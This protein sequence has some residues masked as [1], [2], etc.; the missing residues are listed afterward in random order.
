MNSSS[1]ISASPDSD[2]PTSPRPRREWLRE[3]RFLIIA[4]VVTAFVASLSI[5]ACGPGCCYVFYSIIAGV[6]GVLMLRRPFSS[7]CICLAVLLLSLFGMGHEKEVR[8][9]WGQ[10]ALRLQ[11]Q[12]LQQKLEKTQSTP[13]NTALEPTATAS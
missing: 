5:A 9:T 6:S 2:T 13:P 1:I 7:R 10:R 3:L 11:I 8:D 4:Y 12:N